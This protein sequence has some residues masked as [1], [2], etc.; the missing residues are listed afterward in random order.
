MKKTTE[1]IIVLSNYVRNTIPEKYKE[2]VP[3][4]G[5]GPFVW[6]L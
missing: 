4:V 5:A 2:V 6:N 1:E 3:S